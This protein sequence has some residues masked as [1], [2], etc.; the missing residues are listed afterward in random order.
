[1]AWHLYLDKSEN[2][3][4]KQE[5]VNTSHTQAYSHIQVVLLLPSCKVK[6]TA[7]R[8]DFLLSCI[9]VFRDWGTVSPI[10]TKMKV[11]KHMAK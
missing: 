7:K 4:P 8:T 9:S 3:L 6:T 2:D 10:L 1:M 5:N 11:E